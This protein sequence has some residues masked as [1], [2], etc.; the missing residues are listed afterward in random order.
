MIA[1]PDVLVLGAGGALGERWMRGVLAGL[2]DAGGMDLAAA[3]HIVGTSAGAIVAAD[4]MAGRLPVGPSE[5]GEDRGW[6]EVEDDDEE[7][8]GSRLGAI[9]AGAFGGARWIARAVPSKAGRAVRTAAGPLAPYALTASQPPRALLRA[10]VLGRIEPPRA[11]LDELGGRLARDG[12]R[13]DGRLRVVCVERERGRRVVF[14]SPAAPAATVAEAV[15]ASCSVP[16]LYRGVRI[17]EHEYVDGGLWSPTSIDA[18]PAGRD[19]RVLCLNP[20]GSAARDAAPNG[21]I[22]TASRSAAALEAAALRRRGADVTLIA[23]DPAAAAALAAPPGEPDVARRAL[24]A[25]YR[26]GVALARGD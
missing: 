14:G 1:Q 16:W 22:R 11:S 8:G 21:A 24:A 5:G 23:P 9:A 12:L 7:S 20:S 26:Q 25:G 19:A 4:L 13:F 18:A 3:E 2:A 10:S 6:L 17:G 15:Q